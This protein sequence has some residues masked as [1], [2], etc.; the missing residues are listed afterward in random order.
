MQAWLDSS[1]GQA[2][3]GPLLAQAPGQGGGGGLSM[4]MLFLPIGILFYLLILR[5]QRKEQAERDTMLKALQKNDRVVTIG[6]V[7]G[8]ITNLRE[9]IDEVTIRVD[10]NTN[11]KLRITRSSVARVLSTD[12]GTAAGAEGRSG[13]S[14]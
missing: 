13:G 8:V 9:D 2:V 10:E 12:E 6:G 7:Y 14:N 11:T 4:L 1:I 3:G 5:P